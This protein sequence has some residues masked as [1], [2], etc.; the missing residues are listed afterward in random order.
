MRQPKYLCRILNIYLRLLTELSCDILYDAIIEFV[1]QSDCGGYERQHRRL[2][3]AANTLAPPLDG[4]FTQ[5]THAL[6]WMRFA[7]LCISMCE[8]LH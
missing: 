1:F 3:R 6:H 8:R 5:F 2:P 7:A 4:A